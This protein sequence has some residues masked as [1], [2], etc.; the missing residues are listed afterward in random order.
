V[1]VN[2]TAVFPADTAT[3]LLDYLRDELDLRAAKEGCG[4]GE[5]GSCTVLMNARPVCSCLVLVG[6][7]ADAEIV[8]AEALDGRDP[9][10]RPGLADRLRSAL[11]AAHAPQCGY[12]IPGLFVSAH[13]VL[14][15]HAA[16]TDE[17]IC[18][19]LEGNLCR[20]TGYR[21]IVKAIQAVGG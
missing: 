20:C 2:G 9:E 8:T 10:G 11:V 21:S 12:C 19:A 18:C 16:P 15:E 17:Q 5:C 4:M 1:K 13:A 3:R 14:A 6:Q 7:A